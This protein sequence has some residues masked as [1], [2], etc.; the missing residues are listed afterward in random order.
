MRKLILTLLLLQFI[1]TA[2]V[3]YQMLYKDAETTLDEKMIGYLLYWEK[4]DKIKE[5]T[6]MPRDRRVVAYKNAIERVA[7]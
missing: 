4:P 1:L 6:L 5:I 3:S 2:C 7:A